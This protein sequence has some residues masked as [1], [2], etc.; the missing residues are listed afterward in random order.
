MTDKR[1]EALNRSDTLSLTEEEIKEGWHF[2]LDFDGL[3]VGPETAEATVCICN[4]IIKQ[5]RANND[6]DSVSADRPL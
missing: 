3:L 4:D 2:C 1:Y 5:I 6:S